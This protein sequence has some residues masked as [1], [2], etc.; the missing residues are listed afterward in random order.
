MKEVLIYKYMLRDVVDNCFWEVQRIRK[1]FVDELVRSE[2][3]VDAID[4]M[5]D[6]NKLLKAIYDTKGD[7]VTPDLARKVSL[8]YKAEQELV[9]DIR[10]YLCKEYAINYEKELT[11]RMTKK[12][13]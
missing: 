8:Y 10:Y 12:N 1:Y 13:K 7:Y 6:S 3:S 11:K 2:F 5:E 4:N 9:A